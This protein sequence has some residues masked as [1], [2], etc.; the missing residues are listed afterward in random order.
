MGR[1][2]SFFVDLPVERGVAAERRSRFAVVCSEGRSIDISVR[3]PAYASS[4]RWAP[5]DK[6]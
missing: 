4:L 6:L 1:S 3:L 5:V 2:N